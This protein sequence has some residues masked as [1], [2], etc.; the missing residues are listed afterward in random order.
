[1]RKF[2]H[3]KYT[4]TAQKSA[5]AQLA[6]NVGP[7]WLRFDVDFAENGDIISAR[8]VQSEYWVM[9]HYTLFMQVVS[10]LLTSSWISRDSA[11]NVGDAVTVEPPEMSIPGS[12][13]PADGSFWAEVV[14][15]S[16]PQMQGVDESLRVYGVRPFGASPDDA[17]QHVQRQHLRHR[18]K[19][20]IAFMHVSDDKKHDSWAAQF[21][22]NAS[23]KILK[24]RYVD[25]GVEQFMALH[26]HSDNASSHFKS[27]KTMYYMTSLLSTCATWC[28]GMTTATGVAL[29]FRVFWEFGPPGHGKGVW[30]GLGA[31]AKRTVRQDIIDDRADHKTILTASGVIKTEQEV[32][33][34]LTARFAT[35]EWMQAHTE[36]TINEIVVT[37]A[38]ST[39]IQA[40]RPSVE[41]KYARLVGMK[42]TFM[43]MGLRLGVVG[44]R[45]FSCWCPAC[46]KASS[47]G[48]GTM[49][50]S[51]RCFG[52]SSPHLPWVEKTVDRE[53]AAG[54]ANARTATRAHARSLASRLKTALSRQG[55]NA[56]GIWVAVQNRGED[57]EDQYWIGQAVRIEK[58]HTVSGYVVGTGGR[59]RY[60]A[61]DLEIEVIWYERDISGGDDRRTFI[62]MQTHASSSAVTNEG[63]PP[64]YTFN[65]MEL[66]H[67]FVKMEEVPPVGG[68]TTVSQR[69]TR[70]PRH[71]ARFG[72]SIR[73]VL[74]VVHAPRVQLPLQLWSIPTSEENL[75][76]SYCCP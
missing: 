41:P 43:Y 40:T 18:K 29:A 38:D 25:R 39:E 44:Q 13:Q 32:A 9:K 73:G 27:A 57:D 75:I 34:H 71:P 64:K 19:H 72:Q 61:G 4:I 35:P 5:I 58:E 33:E 16:G 48:Q 28:A 49:D 3:H 67:I 1:M 66:R 46:M 15:V 30:D 69:L 76:L 51:L 52:C 68:S 59:V 45:A 12:L 20:T 11:L 21:F 26:I 53:D 22:L 31:L 17:P 36:K 62:R 70:V 47:P 60:D 37:Y 63:S 42:Q 65:S 8:E 23:L 50:T 2:P 6:R 7:G 54:I 55:P 74:Q 14:E 56:E 10:F 24:E